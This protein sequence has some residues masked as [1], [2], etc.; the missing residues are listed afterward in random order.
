MSSLCSET[1]YKQLR[2][3]KTGKKEEGRENSMTAR[4]KMEDEEG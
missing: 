3:E 4:K 2:R 1:L